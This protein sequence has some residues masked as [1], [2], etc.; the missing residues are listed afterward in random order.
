VGQGYDTAAPI[1]PANHQPWTSPQW[2][3]AT[4]QLGA[5]VVAA[6][7]TRLVVGN[8]IANG[9]QYF[10]PSSGPTANLLNG[11]A[12][13]N[14]QGFIRS[15]ADALTN[16]RSVKAWKNDVDM[17]A[18]AGGRGRFVMAM[19]KVDKPG[20][21]AQLQQVHRYALAS[22]LLGTN[23]T[24]YFHFSPN[25]NDDGVNAPDTPDDHV[26]PGMPLASYVAQRNGAYTRAFSAGYVAVNP[27][28]TTVT[29]SLGGTYFDLDG[30][31]VQQATLPPHTGMVF[32]TTSSTPSVT[33]TT[34]TPTTTPTPPTTTPCIR[35]RRATASGP[36]STT[37]A[38][39]PLTAAARRCRP[40]RAP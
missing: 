4:S 28:T 17:L 25:G 22:F 40:R 21:P 7:P 13:A 20:T 3:A 34:T 5:T 11:V 8:G 23:G 12:G 33:T 35:P 32:T 14:A 10:D 30:N 26:N 16:F 27:G 6:Q 38:K 37:A 9:N 36:A 31:S 24:Q 15:E 18:N 2:I 39:Q 29:V 19:T 1:N